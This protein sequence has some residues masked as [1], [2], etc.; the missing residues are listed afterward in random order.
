LDELEAKQGLGKTPIF[1][2]EGKIKEWEGG[3]V[4][5]GGKARI[6]K[7]QNRH[8]SLPQGGG[9]GEKRK[10]KARHGPSKNKNRSQKRGMGG[11]RILPT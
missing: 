6:R 5:T 1:F 3:K 4:K 9:S 2:W 8:R 7:K 10:G 11:T